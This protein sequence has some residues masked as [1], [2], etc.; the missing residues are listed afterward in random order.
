MSVMITTAQLQNSAINQSSQSE[1][2]KAAFRV[3]ESPGVR[4]VT[5]FTRQEMNRFRQRDSEKL[6]IMNKLGL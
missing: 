5:H 3:T 1:T 6:S 4:C 2:C